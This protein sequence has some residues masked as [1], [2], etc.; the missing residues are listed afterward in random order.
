MKQEFNPSELRI[1][2]VLIE[3]SLTTPAS[4]P[5]T[6]NAL[7]AGANQ[8]QNRDPVLS[9]SETDV[10]R[11]VF[12]LQQYNVVEQAPPSANA[13]SNRY[14]H[15]ASERFN[16]DK[17]EQAVMA[18]LLL[19]GRQTAGEIRNRAMRMTPIPDMHAVHAILA[20]L[21]NR[22]IPFAKELQR[23]PGRSTNR[24]KHLMDEDDKT[25]AVEKN[26]LEVGDTNSCDSAT[27]DTAIDEVSERL[28][29]MEKRIEALASRIVPLEK[30]IATP[31]DGSIGDEV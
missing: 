12:R 23:E 2:G 10:S 18:E 25:A 21:I 30:A 17:R 8:Q 14:H 27:P 3:K 29:A 4:Y 28:A 16:W 6:M 13:R 20:G 19:R 15:R 24:Y 31:L 22:D 9:L 11:A 5:L 7:L 26:G 1:L